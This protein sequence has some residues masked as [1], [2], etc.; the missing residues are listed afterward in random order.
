M[1]ALPRRLLGNRELLLVPLPLVI[2]LLAGASAGST[3]R[4]V[5]VALINVVLVAGLF[6][7]IGNSGIMSFGHIA[8]AAIGGYAAALVAIDPSYKELVLEGMPS[9]LAGFQVSTTISVLI[10]A[11]VAALAGLVVAVPLM[12]LAGLAAGLATFALLEIV[13]TTAA[14]SDSITGGA[15]GLSSIPTST[16]LTVAGVWA[17]IALLVV[18]V[19]GATRSGLLLRASRGDEVAARAAGIRVE[20]ERGIAFVLSAALMGAGG[21]L[22]VEYLGSVSP[23]TFYLDLTFATLTMLVVGGIRTLAGAFLGV[24][25]MSAVGELLRRMQT[26]PV[27]G[28]EIPNRPGIQAVVFA[29][30]LLAVVMLRPQGL[31]GGSG[32]PSNR[33]GPLARAR[34][35]LSG[36]EAPPAPST[37]IESETRRSA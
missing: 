12:R 14:A 18:I 13:Q 29:A 20:R 23:D 32:A 33:P 25:L 17:S 9:W 37:E 19:Y 27:V 3:Q 11:G 35:A 16:D 2:A 7:F 31:L 15:A 6:A 5:I 34:A 28:I 10:G 22:Y 1:S 8:I 21:A 24:W 4:F 36:K 30:I 26:E